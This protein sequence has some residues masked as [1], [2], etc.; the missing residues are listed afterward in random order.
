MKQTRLKQMQN[1]MIQKL[2][3]QQGKRVATTMEKE[4]HILCS[5]DADRPQDLLQHLHNN[6]FPVAATFRALLKEGMSR[7]EAAKLAQDA[8]LELM[9]KPADTIRK[10]CKIP[11]FY[12]RIPWLFEK[13]MPKLFKADAGFVFKFH[14]TGK[15]RVKFDILSCPYYEVCLELDCLELA[16]AFCTT[17]DICYGH[18]HPKLRWNRTQTLARGGTLCDFDI[19]VN[20]SEKR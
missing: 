4:Y 18:M 3:P 19:E 10:L 11:G 14:P 1:Q 16:P 20:D 12:R 13:L 5:T 8:F 17:D 15:H 7:E 6:I 9:E 2:N